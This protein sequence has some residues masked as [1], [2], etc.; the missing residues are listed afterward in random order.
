MVRLT[1]NDGIDLVIRLTN[2]E[3][4]TE[5][6]TTVYGASRGVLLQISGEDTTVILARP[7]WV[8][9]LE[10]GLLYCRGVMA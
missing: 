8:D 6:S 2:A 9:K 1:S 10:G 5:S 4:Y 7:Q 3:P